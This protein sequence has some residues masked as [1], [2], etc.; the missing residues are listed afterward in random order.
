[1]FSKT[2]YRSAAF[3][4]VS[5]CSKT[6]SY[7]VEIWTEFYESKKECSKFTEVLRH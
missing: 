7:A 4:P 3:P 1:M 6:Q 2:Q 5:L